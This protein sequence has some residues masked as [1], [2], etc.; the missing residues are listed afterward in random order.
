MNHIPH[1]T[2]RWLP[3]LLGLALFLFIGHFALDAFR[4]D[5]PLTE[6]V[7]DFLVHLVPALIILL[8]VIIGWQRPI[9]AGMILILLAIGYAVWAREHPS[10]ILAISG[11]VALIG[12]LFIISDLLARPTPPLRR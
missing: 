10:W 8:V 3:R 5:V 4:A 1:L 12:G 11:P 6:Q 2:L 7:L 9:V